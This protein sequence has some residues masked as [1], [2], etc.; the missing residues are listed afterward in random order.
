MNEEF[1]GLGVMEEDGGLPG[2]EEEPSHYVVSAEGEVSEYE[3][4]TSA[5]DSPLDNEE[6]E[7]AYKA[8]QPPGG[9]Y[10]V[11]KFEAT[12]SEREAEYYVQVED[13]FKKVKQ[14]RLVTTYAGKGLQERDGKTWTPH[15]RVRVSPI[16]AYAKDKDGQVVPDKLDS[17]SKLFQHAR[18][19]Y[20]EVLGEAPK[21]KRD[22]DI[23][24]R[25]YPFKVLTMQLP[26]GTLLVLGLQGVKPA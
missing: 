6:E 11:E 25:T 17:A 10:L 21:T 7:K 5:W 23:F 1:G 26:D 22:I 18:I 4:P 12:E 8:T 9:Y 16:R 19:A 20:K 14:P 3:P 15:L 13:G 2:F 24:L